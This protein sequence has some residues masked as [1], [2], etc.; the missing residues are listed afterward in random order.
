MTGHYPDALKR[1]HREVSDFNGHHFTRTTVVQ[2]LMEPYQGRIVAGRN[3]VSVHKRMDVTVGV[4][5]EAGEKTR[6]FSGPRRIERGA[7]IYRRFC[8]I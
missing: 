3:I 5:S 4:D 2:R 1:N 6:E 8:A 7:L